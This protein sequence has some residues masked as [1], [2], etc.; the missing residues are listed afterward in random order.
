M[1]HFERAE[2][3]RP[4]ARPAHVPERAMAM[5]PLA[6]AMVVGGSFLFLLGLVCLAAQRSEAGLVGST[7]AIG[8]SA[9]VVAVGLIYLLATR[10]RELDRDG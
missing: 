5:R 7:L 8:T 9:L 4:S 2:R 3:T 6:L 10:N 1:S